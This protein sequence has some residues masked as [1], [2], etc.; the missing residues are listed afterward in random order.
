MNRK[1]SASKMSVM[2]EAA[3]YEKKARPTVPLRMRIARVDQQEASEE[4]KLQCGVHYADI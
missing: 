1:I 3:T 4:G 2:A